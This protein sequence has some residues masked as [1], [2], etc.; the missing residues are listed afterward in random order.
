MVSLIWRIRRELIGTPVNVAVLQTHAPGAE[1]E[2]NFGEFQA[3]I[4]LRSS[5]LVPI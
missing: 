5:S 1:A 2:V 4:R 3:M